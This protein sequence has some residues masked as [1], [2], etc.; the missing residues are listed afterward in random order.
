MPTNPLEAHVSAF[1]VHD[2]S[3]WL[4]PGEIVVIFV[5]RHHHVAGTLQEMFVI[6]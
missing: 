3:I 1:A 5:L 4:H 2:F 6:E